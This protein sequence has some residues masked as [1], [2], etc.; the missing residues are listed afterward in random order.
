MLNWYLNAELVEF[1]VHVLRFHSD[2]QHTNR[3][4]AARATAAAHIT[5]NESMLMLIHT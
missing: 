5:G 2:T 1:R 4:D 3:R